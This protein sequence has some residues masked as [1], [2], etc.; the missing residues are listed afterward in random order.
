ME[1]AISRTADAPGVARVLDQHI[2]QAGKTYVQAL[3]D[4]AHQRTVSKRTRLREKLGDYLTAT[5]S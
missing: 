3:S 2:D 4:R 5:S 1:E